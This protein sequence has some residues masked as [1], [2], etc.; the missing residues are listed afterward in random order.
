MYS[1]VDRSFLF[2]FV[3][4]DGE[5]KRIQEN[6]CFPTFTV[7]QTYGNYC[8]FLRFQKFSCAFLAFSLTAN[9]HEFKKTPVFQCSPYDELWENIVSSCVHRNFLVF[10]G[11][12]SSG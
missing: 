11:T 10:S 1:D 5:F 3:F 2:S 8:A 12:V 7:W 4:R 9:T 6:V